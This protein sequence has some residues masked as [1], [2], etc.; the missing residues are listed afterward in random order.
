M[1]CQQSTSQVGVFFKRNSLSQR[2]RLTLKT[3]DV[4]YPFISGSSLAT[5]SYWNG[6]PFEKYGYY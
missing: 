2:L 6:M 3:S 1:Q 4:H 5:R